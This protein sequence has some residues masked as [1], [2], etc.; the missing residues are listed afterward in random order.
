MRSFQPDAIV[1]L[2]EM[3]SAPK[4]MMDVR[5]CVS[6]QQNNI[7]GTLNILYAM[8]E[9]CPQSHLVK[10]GTMGEYGTPNVA[11]FCTDISAKSRLAS[12]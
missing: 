8:K 5:H 9:C 7:I 12:D 10:L 1:H 11:S 6:T 4:S 3:P 2:G